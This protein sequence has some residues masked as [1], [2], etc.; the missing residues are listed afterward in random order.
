[1]VCIQKRLQLYRERHLDGVAIRGIEHPGCSGDYD[2]AM[3]GGNV[4][5]VNSAEEHSKTFIISRETSTNLNADVWL[6]SEV[7]DSGERSTLFAN[8]LD[9]A[10]S[11]Y[12]PPAAGWM[13]VGDYTGKGVPLIGHYF[14]NKKPEKRTMA[15][16]SGAGVDEINLPF[17]ESGE[18]EGAPSFEVST[19]SKNYFLRRITNS[20]KLLWII[21][22]KRKDDDGGAEIYYVNSDLGALARPPGAA[23]ILG[24]HGKLPIPQINV[25]SITV[26]KTSEGKTVVKKISKA[27]E[28]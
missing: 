13:P 15:I 28:T 1:M 25:K 14:A 17:K 23:W 20:D 2:R 9:T 21:A 8:V 10:A 24:Q 26:E 5:F 12:V 18:Y 22:G 7:H 4:V 16:I 3:I 6:L 11:K 27:I 19:E